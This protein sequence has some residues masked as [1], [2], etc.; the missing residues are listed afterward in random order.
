MFGYGLNFSLI[1]RC[2]ISSYH[3]TIVTEIGLIACA[4]IV[5]TTAFVSEYW[6]APITGA[7][8]LG[9]ML[10]IFAFLGFV[11]NH[12]RTR[13]ETPEYIPSSDRKD[14]AILLPASCF[15]DSQFAHI[16]SKL[17]T[18]ERDKVGYPMKSYQF[19]EF[20][21]WIVLLIVLVAGIGRG[22]MQLRSDRSM[23][24]NTYSLWKGVIMCLY[25]AVALILFTIMT[26]IAWSR[27]Y[28]F[29]KWVAHSGWMKPGR[30]SNPADDWLENG[31]ILPML[32]L[33]VIGIFI[34]N[35]Y[36]LKFYSSN[37]KTS[38]PQSDI[39]LTDMNSQSWK[40]GLRTG[41]DQFPEIPRCNRLLRS[42]R[43]R[44]TKLSINFS[45]CND[46]G[47]SGILIHDYVKKV[48]EWQ[49]SKGGRLFI[50]NGPLR[51]LLFK[52]SNNIKRCCSRGYGR[53]R[54][55]SQFR[56]SFTTPYT[57]L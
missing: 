50:C 8:R 52:P 22:I 5:L 39:E 49:K 25:K 57:I 21:L 42:E 16:Y 34:F 56:L 36:E 45:K 15:L 27:I 44:C 12:Q 11:L 17:T 32:Q 14:S 7:L 35:E 54:V 47:L 24:A 40:Q 43:L 33:V 55:S 6:K 10:T 29:R 2:T 9:A 4:N 13:I 18:S 28:L 41:L 19:W 1:Q 38:S 48:Q 51:L 37:P 3:Y 46:N 23:R 53:R 26:V 31:Q 30:I 20:P